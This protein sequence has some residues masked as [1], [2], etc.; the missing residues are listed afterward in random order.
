MQGDKETQRLTDE[1]MT[2]VNG[3]S[4]TFLGVAR[5]SPVFSEGVCRFM[6]YGIEEGYQLWT[7]AIT[8]AYCRTR[9]YS[10]GQQD[11]AWAEF[12][13]STNRSTC[14]SGHGQNKQ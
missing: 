3:D 11:P 9:Q 6:V 7:G 10:T 5:K 13:A 12:W 2:T 8:T 1:V 4:G 14:A